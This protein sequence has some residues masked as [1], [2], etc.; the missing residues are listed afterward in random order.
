MKTLKIKHSAVYFLLSLLNSFTFAQVPSVEWS[1][2][3]DGA[4]LHD[5]AKFVRL[6]AQGNIIV[7]GTT[8][9]GTSSTYVDV[10]TRKYAPNGDLL[11]SHKW[12][13]D[14]L[15]F[16]DYPRDM[17]ITPDNSIIVTGY[18]KIDASSSNNSDMFV[19]ALDA[20]GNLLWSDSI[21]GSGYLS[22][23]ININ[24]NR[25]TSL[26]I[27]ASGDIIITGSS[28]G[29]G[30]T[31][32]D[33]ML[34]VKYNL[35]GHR[36]WLRY[37]NNSNIH[38]YAD[39]GQSVGVDAA[40]N[41]YVCGV[42]T[43]TT[44]WRDMAVWKIDSNGDF[45]WINTIPGP[46]NNTSEQFDNINVDANGNSYSLGINSNVK[47]YLAKHDS[48]GAKQWDYVFDTVN[49]NNTASFT[50]ADMPLV[51]DNSGNLIVAVNMNTQMGV[52]KFS[53]DGNLLW[54]K[55]YGGTGQWSNHVY[56]VVTDANNNIYV[57]GSYSNAGS[58]YFD[59][60]AFKLD[61]NGNQ[62]WSYSYD[63]PNNQNDKAHSIAIAQDGSIYLAGFS[64]GHSA[65]ADLY[66]VKLQQSPTSSIATPITNNLIT[67]YPNPASNIVTINNIP[68]HSTISIIDMTGKLIYFAT[69]SNTQE[70]I[71][72]EN[73]VN[74][75]YF[76]QVENNNSVTNSKLVVNK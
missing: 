42:T 31:E 64:S 57:A 56:H 61:E 4:G 6:D 62:L 15:N 75:V 7:T 13:N 46:V 30:T 28:S 16:S 32:F 21:R 5:E 29:N 18:S 60:G 44:T 72:T 22:G 34:L 10:I 45:R 76:I 20:D 59:L 11:W 51:L 2:T 65:S 37:F 17:D 27:T 68:S 58:S 3:F 69:N 14:N 67:I 71:N 48:T 63:G 52:A 12:N 41:A 43:L 66:L 33:Q 74:G 36:Q 25:G 47:F 50:G 40:G 19:F 53:P 35:S 1:R 26:Q 54:L 49:V 55:L 39:Y 9:S 23:S 8:N 73:L 70:T 38:E 24:Q